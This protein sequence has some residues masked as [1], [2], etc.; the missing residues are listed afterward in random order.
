MRFK[1][2]ISFV[3]ALLMLFSETGAYASDYSGNAAVPFVLSEE[4]YSDV[5][6]ND[7][8][9]VSTDENITDDIKE[10]EAS[11]V[12]GE[13]SVI[14]D[15]DEEDRVTAEKLELVA[16]PYVTEFYYG[17][18]Y[19]MY[20]FVG[21]DYLNGLTL[22]I[23]YSNGKQEIKKHV[24]NGRRSADD[25]PFNMFDNFC[26]CQVLD[27]SG[28]EIDSDRY[29]QVGEY[30]VRVWL[31]SAYADF[32]IKILPD[33]NMSELTVDGEALHITSGKFYEDYE[34]NHLKLVVPAGKSVKVAFEKE[35]E[36]Y[37]QWYV[38]GIT[39]Y[40]FKGDAAYPTYDAVYDRTD[41]FI[42][43]NESKEARTYYLSFLN[44]C[45]V[46]VSA[47]T[48]KSIKKIDISE[49]DEEDRFYELFTDGNQLN[50]VNTTLK[51]TYED[52][53]TENIDY[54]KVK[55]GSYG[56]SYRVC[57]VSG[58]YVAGPLPW[59]NDLTGYPAGDYIVK[60]YTSGQE[61]TCSYPVTV[62]SWKDIP[63]I[64]KDASVNVNATTK[65]SYYTDD[66][67][68][69]AVYY[70]DLEP[71]DYSLYAKGNEEFA[72][73][74]FDADCKR[75]NKN[76]YVV[77]RQYFTVTTAGR[78]YIDLQ[79]S[80]DIVL[81]LSEGALPK[82]IKMVKEPLDT[83]FVY[84]FEELKLTGLSAKIV[85][86]DGTE[87]DTVEYGTN[88]FYQLFDLINYTDNGTDEYG[89]LK[90]GNYYWRLSAKNK[91]DIYT[92]ITYSVV[93]YEIDGTIT[94]GTDISLKCNM[95]KLSDGG[96]TS[97]DENGAALP[98]YLIAMELTAGK[99]YRITTGLNYYQTVCLYDT[100]Y[101]S[102]Y[103]DSQYNYKAKETGTYFLK[104]YTTGTTISVE[105]I[106]GIEGIK[107]LSGPLVNK[108]PAGDALNRYNW[109]DAGIELLLTLEDGTTLECEVNDETWDYYELGVG[110]YLGKD[111]KY[112]N[113]YIAGEDYYYSIIVPYSTIDVENRELLKV[114][115]VSRES[116]TIPFGK[117]YVL[118]L[119]DE[120]RGYGSPEYF[121]NLSAGKTYRFNGTGEYSYN[122]YDTSGKLLV[123]SQ[124]NNM[125]KAFEYTSEIDQTVALVLSNNFFDNT[126]S[127]P[128]TI[129]VDEVS[130]TLRAKVT[131]A[132]Q[133]TTFEYGVVKPAPIGAVITLTTEAGD[134]EVGYE[135][136][137]RY[138]ISYKVY[139]TYKHMCLFTYPAKG[140]YIFGYEIP[141]IDEV[142]Y[143][144]EHTFR[145]IKA[146]KNYKVFFNSNY[147]VTDKTNTKTNQ[148]IATNRYVPLAANTFKCD[149]YVFEGW[150][151][152][153]DGKA[154]YSDKE[155]VYNI[156]GEDASVELYAKW[157]LAEYTIRWHLSGGD[158]EDEFT[159]V[160]GYD[161]YSDTV[162]LPTAENIKAVTGFTFAGWYT[163]PDH[164][165]AASD[166]TKGST[167]NKDFYARWEL[168][169]YTV[170][171]EG[172]GNSKG[173]S[174]NDQTVYY[175]ID[176]TLSKCAFKDAGAF[177]GWSF[178]PDGAVEF[179]DKEV[180][181]FKDYI[182]RFINGELTLYAVWKKTFAISADLNGGAYA[183]GKAMPSS[184]TYGQAVNL[185]TPVRT[186]YTFKGWYLDTGF[187]KKFTKI[188]KSTTGDLSLFA[189]WEPVVYTLKLDGNGGSGKMKNSSVKYDESVTIPSCIYVKKG[190]RFAG[191][192]SSSYKRS[193]AALESEEAFDAFK[194]DKTIYQPETVV[195]N[196]ESGK[197]TVI[198]SAVWVRTKYVAIFNTNGGRT[199]SDIEYYYNSEKEA[200][201]LP[202]APTREGYEF[203]GWYSD[204]DLTKKLTKTKGL[205][206]TIHIYA[207]W[208]K[209]YEVI[210]NKAHDEATGSMANESMVFGDAKALTKNSFNRDGYVFMGWDTDESAD[211][212]V[213]TDKQK[214]TGIDGL[215]PLNLYA[216]WRKDFNITYE[217]NGGRLS[218]GTPSSYNY[219]TGAT[220]VEPTKSG[221]KFGGWYSDAKFKKSVKKIS[222]TMR[223]DITLYA[224]WTGLK[225]TVTFDANA[226]E[227]TVA[228]GKTGKTT[229]TWGTAKILTRNGFKI[230][231]YTFKG[232]ATSRNG[233]VKYENAS[234]VSDA[235]SEDLK[236]KSLG[237]Y[238]QTKTLYAVWEKDTYSI[239]YVM[240]G[241]LMDL[242]IEHA[243]TVD[244]GYTH[245]E[246][247]RIGYTFLGFYTDKACKKKATDLKP[248]TTGNKI[249]YA[250]WKVNK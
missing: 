59:K 63:E 145:V 112:A 42:L 38:F 45:D 86:D 32:P 11:S 6:P 134:V 130:P 31:D 193:A 250:K 245:M 118:P 182:D 9:V 247:E 177:M 108:V 172:N 174:M 152:T 140:T 25:V 64:K 200:F 7:P 194:A 212:V 103:L 180:V 184:Y 87:S 2:S 26:T 155:A 106:P 129:W 244:S 90:V 48:V 138:G 27:K 104:V 243:Y 196:L 21:G 101:K 117:E 73:R 14:T 81:T 230:N 202:D 216:V 249:F 124:Y 217:T 190:Y 122:I 102:I 39:P 78:Y 127:A 72:I 37:E 1:R 210:F 49:N 239:K 211:E 144:S 139:D 223:G 15:Y 79:T 50:P 116:L 97:E 197:T 231:G 113:E 208:K 185:H 173:G 62:K 36:C 12:S 92:D 137:A 240:N 67:Y 43:K 141:G 165:T 65:R 95:R 151:L 205:Y 227:G 94:P 10:E 131:T 88:E 154:I 30:T 186:G 219:G 225:C 135:D 53:S 16:P 75:I 237:Y 149:G 23:T 44:Q 85:Y 105:N 55:N 80:K 215:F 99:T 233:E 175:G 218:F 248:G 34:A 150:A 109:P 84:G 5:T 188:T 121:V 83:E 168:T 100:E 204:K 114:S 171:F 157:T 76:S 206:G 176:E 183:E 119:N 195:S 128:C 192:V 61:L 189:R 4:A 214:I 163:T 169:P 136:F 123:E 29:N 58:N 167:G 17:M 89:K 160:T 111:G 18:N 125:I 20:T 162:T 220:L 107:V 241:V 13:D 181:N 238:S 35:E 24:Y 3:L 236:V 47:E 198:L 166:V 115:V 142:V 91:K 203:A 209:A 57:D 179:K 96:Y 232:W 224:K 126:H 143:D 71:G 213:F 56:I 156:A 235:D 133:K 41:N 66:I 52:D 147:P 226:P 54:Y 158:F 146:D 33:E 246:P 82:E 221:Y 46:K 229:L 234:K 8:A 199:V 77:T 222:E 70:M 161:I 201:V 69:S 40:Y 74:I 170:H 178:T 98:F 228:K 60:F 164:R 110:K 191:W 68:A 159:P 22:K 148:K 19:G 28:K 242:T 120:D 153:A 207:K 187:T 51:I 132:P 93:P